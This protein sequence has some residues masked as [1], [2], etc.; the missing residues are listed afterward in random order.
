MFKTGWI[1]RILR[2]KNDGQTDG[3]AP[4]IGVILNAGIK[5]IC[6][7]LVLTLVPEIVKNY[8]LKPSLL[9]MHKSI[10]GMALVW[11]LVIG[12]ADVLLK[13]AL[14]VFCLFKTEWVVAL[15]TGERRINWRK[16]GAVTAAVLFVLVLLARRVAVLQAQGLD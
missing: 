3:A 1:A 8:T 13:L 11:D 5:L 4:G 10:D 9:Y 7:Y 16:T 14:A 15:V 6:V 2:I 12:G